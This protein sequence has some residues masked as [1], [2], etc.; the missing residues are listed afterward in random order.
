MRSILPGAFANEVSVL[1]D[2]LTFIEEVLKQTYETGRNVLWAPVTVWFN[3]RVK[4]CYCQLRR[5]KFVRRSNTTS[6]QDASKSEE[7]EFLRSEKEA[8][9]IV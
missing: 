8:I 3:N 1:I 7:I 5:L 4:Q 2:R 9:T 6:R